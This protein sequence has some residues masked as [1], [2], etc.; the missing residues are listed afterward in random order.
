MSQRDNTSS[1]GANDG[2]EGKHKGQNGKSSRGEHS[3][4]DWGGYKFPRNGVSESESDPYSEEDDDYESF[5]ESTH[6][7]DV[8]DGEIATDQPRSTKDDSDAEDQDD[9]TR[10]DPLDEIKDYSLDKSKEKYP[11]KY[12]R[13]HLT[14]DK[15]Q[16]A[17]LDDAPCTK[18]KTR[19]WN[20]HRWM[21]ILVT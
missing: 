12:F 19:F 6:N 10:F 17:I 18:K 9:T 8:E 3:A 16:T 4:K 20:H 1:K 14:E 21:S 15:I 11:K 5:D 2:P 7:S 13:F